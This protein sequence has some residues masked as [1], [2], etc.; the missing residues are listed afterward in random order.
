VSAGLD[1]ESTSADDD[2]AFDSFTP[3]ARTDVLIRDVDDGV[4][5][6][7]PIGSEPLQLQPL[8]AAVLQ[9]LDGDVTTSALVADL[10][11]VLEVPEA[12][13]RELLRRELSL[14]DRAG[15]LTSSTPSVEPE[16]GL[17]VFP[18]PP[19]P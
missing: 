5:A 2:A 10:C 8:S 3:R 12:V 16:G 15:L 17:D 4:V 19:N 13:A 9:L 11:E 14:L 18:A 6:W 7:S 1:A